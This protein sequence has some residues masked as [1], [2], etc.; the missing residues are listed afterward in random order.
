MSFKEI[1]SFL[2]LE[3]LLDV[4]GQIVEGEAEERRI[5]GAVREWLAME[6]N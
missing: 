1:A 6:Y 3:G 2:R 4:N 5:T